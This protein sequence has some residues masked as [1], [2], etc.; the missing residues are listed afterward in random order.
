MIIAFILFLCLAWFGPR[1]NLQWLDALSLV[2]I[3]VLGASFCLGW[4]VCDYFKD[5]KIH[6]QPPIVI[7]AKQ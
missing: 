4:I 5:S 7:E 1:M 3:G 6:F 2:V